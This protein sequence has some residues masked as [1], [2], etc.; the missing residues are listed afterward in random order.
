MKK[1]LGFSIL[2][3]LSVLRCLEYSA[4][5]VNCRVAGGS[6][7][8]CEILNSSHWC[9]VCSCYADYKLVKRKFVLFS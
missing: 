1:V 5:N 2:H 8:S 3:C 7:G 9:E 6:G 4:A